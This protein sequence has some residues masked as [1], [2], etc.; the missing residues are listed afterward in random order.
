[1]KHALE[2]PIAGL[3]LPQIW[4]RRGPNSEN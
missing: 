1:M 3:F 2:A 4:C